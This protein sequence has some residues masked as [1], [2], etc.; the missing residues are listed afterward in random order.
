MP[1]RPGHLLVPGRIFIRHAAL[2]L[3]SLDYGECDQCEKLAFEQGQNLLW[4]LIGLSHH[5]IASLLQDLR[6]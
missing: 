1:K 4:Q 3:E 6:A 2:K 5:G